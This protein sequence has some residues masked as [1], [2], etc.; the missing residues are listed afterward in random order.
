MT[1]T[2][3]FNNDRNCDTSCPLFISPDDINEFVS[4]RLGSIGVF[5]KTLGECS[6]KMIALSQGRMIFENTTARG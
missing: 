5:N 3:P 1:K 2:C 6:L 4:A